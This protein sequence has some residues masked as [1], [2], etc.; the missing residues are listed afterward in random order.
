MI[1]KPKMQPCNSLS[2]LVFVRMIKTWNTGVVVL[3]AS[4]DASRA[5]DE[6]TFDIDVARK[7]HLRPDLEHDLLANRTQAIER[8]RMR[9]IAVERL[10]HV[11]F[12]GEFFEAVAV[13][14]CDVFL[15]RAQ[16]RREHAVTLDLVA[17][18]R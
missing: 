18:R 16:A 10:E 5:V 1:G 14:E 13:D 2:Q 17:C 3:E 15:V 11:T 6:F 4:D 7:H 9:Q 12:L 8:R